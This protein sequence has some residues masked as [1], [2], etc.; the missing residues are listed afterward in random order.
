MESEIK[1]LVNQAQQGDTEAFGVLYE[2]YYP[3]MKGICIKILKEDKDVVDDLVQDAFILALVSV[4]DLKNPHRF[5]QWLTSITTHLAFKYK[6]K[7]HK[8]QYVSLSDVEEVASEE[9]MEKGTSS[10][11]ISY[12]DLM[13]AIGKLPRGYR[14]VFEMSVLDGLSHQEIAEILNIAPHSSSSQLARA[15]NMLRGLLNAKTLVVIVLAIVGLIYK[16]FMTQEPVPVRKAMRYAKKDYVRK[17]DK[18]SI[19]PIVA[20]KTKDELVASNKHLVKHIVSS[21][22]ES[23]LDS[24]SDSVGRN[25]SVESILPIE[26]NNLSVVDTLPM[27]TDTLLLPNKEW[28]PVIAIEGGKYENAKNKHENGKKKNGKWKIIG[29]GSLGTTLA[30]NVYKTMMGHDG[31]SDGELPSVTSSFTTWEEYSRYLHQ[32]VEN[33]DT[34]IDQTILDIAD[35][36]QGR[37]VEKEH[38]DKPITLGIAINKNIGNNW[39]LETGLQ[40]SFLK[41]T[42]TLGDSEYRMERVQRLHYVGIPLRLSYQFANYKKWSAYGSAGATLHIPVSGKMSVNYVT[43]V[44]SYDSAHYKVTAPLQWVMNTSVGLQ[45]QFAPKWNVFLEP[46]LNWYI[47]TGGNTRNAW[48]ER[49]F[50]FA[51]PFGIRFTW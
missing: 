45:Y 15:K 43:D 32:L 49:P 50:T 23:V 51:V 34:V 4:K 13:A 39:S 10:L 22:A 42:F 19:E 26:H 21:T 6:E 25:L 29:L 38:H 11:S 44:A 16:T 12:D 41:S 31:T 3:K 47:P 17:N 48:T 33:R 46:T 30:Q 9:I 24:V 7:S 2:M 36:N 1:A 18:Q 28:N 5:G 35:H 27:I 8:E 40:Y 20:E 14:D 37:I